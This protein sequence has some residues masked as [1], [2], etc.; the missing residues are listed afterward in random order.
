MRCAGPSYW[1]AGE[2]EYLAMSTAQPLQCPFCIDTHAELTRIAG[3]GDI[4]PDDPASVRPEPRAVGDFLAA[5]TRT[6]DRADATEVADLPEQA[7]RGGC[8]SAWCSTSSTGWPTRSA[9]PSARVSCT[10][11]PAPSTGSATAYPA[12]CSPTARLPAA[13]MPRRIFA[14]R[15]WTRP[16]PPTRRCG[17][18]PQLAAAL[19]T[20]AG[21]RH[22]RSRRLIQDHR[23]RHRPPDRRRAHRRRNHRS[24]HGSGGGRGSQGLRRR[25]SRTRAQDHGLSRGPV[26]RTAVPGRSPG[27]VPCVAGWSPRSGSVPGR[28]AGPRSK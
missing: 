7:V 9:S 8:G 19:R 10:A 1:T 16:P 26:A 6:P 18:R 22:D 15:C 4:D 13:A 11:V 17:R 5:V 21:L 24:H 3:H 25:P 28:R 2:R 23:H 27:T 20:V 12:S 14:M